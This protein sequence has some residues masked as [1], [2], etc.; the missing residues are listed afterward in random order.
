M[1]V[2]GP[3]AAIRH[4]TIALETRR[5]GTAE[6]AEQHCLLTFAVGEPT[7]GRSGRRGATG[8]LVTGVPSPSVPGGS[9]R[10]GDGRRGR[11]WS[12]RRATRG[13]PTHHDAD[14]AHV[15][16]RSGAGR[17]RSATGGPRPPSSRAGPTDATET[18]WPPGRQARRAR[19]SPTSRPAFDAR[20][21]RARRTRGWRRCSARCPWPW[22]LHPPTAAS[23]A[24]T[25]CR[26]APRLRGRGSSSAG[27]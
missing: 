26:G 2:A 23:G 16:V 12:G 22:S 18:A 20:G 13:I 9:V 3:P 27:R 6:R 10:V 21:S 8:H 15:R 19:S 7:M 11:G 25:G 24:G 17:A 5:S 4:C 14:A 1:T